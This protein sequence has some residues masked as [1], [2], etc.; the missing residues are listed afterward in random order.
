MARRRNTADGGARM[1]AAKIAFLALSAAFLF[2]STLVL[3]LAGH[4]WAETEAPALGN[5]PSG[6]TAPAE[7]VVPL[8]A[9]E[10]QVLDRFSE[11]EKKLLRMAEL[12]AATDPHR[13]SLLRKA[14]AQSKQ[15][16]IES[17]LSQ[18][19][20]LLGQDRLA[21]AVKSQAAVGQDLTRLLELLLSEDRSKRLQSEKERIGKYIQ[22]VNQLIKQQKQLQGEA[23]GQADLKQIAEHQ[24]QLAEKTGEL[25]RDIGDSDGDGKDK[26]SPDSKAKPDKAKPD[27]AKPNKPADGKSDGGKSDDGKSDGGKSDGGKSDGGKSSKEGKPGDS[28]P[29]DEQP[30]KEDS[31]KKEPAEDPAAEDTKPEGEKE[32]A[33]KPAGGSPGD[34]Q[35]PDGKPGSD[36][37]SPDGAES[38]GKPAE[39]G[40]PAKGKPGGKPSEGSDESPQPGEEQADGGPAEDKPEEE[41]EKSPVR[42]RVAQAEQKM[43]DAQKKL[44]EAQ[45]DQAVQKQEE[46]KR[47][48][49]LAKAELE[50][51][52]RQLR[53]EEV[54]RTLAMLE[55]RFRKMLEL[56]NQVNTGTKRLD[57]ATAEQRDH[58]DEI[59]AGR[60]S[61]QEAAIVVEANKALAVLHDE[62]SAVAFPE[63]VS[64]LRDDMEQVVVRLAQAKVDAL[65]QGLENDIVVALEEMI[66]ALHS[67]QKQQAPQKGAQSGGE[68]EAPLVDDLS[69]IKM[70]RSMQ[71]W[72]NQ[73]TKRYTEMVKSDAS[74]SPDLIAALRRLADREQRIHRVTRDIVV[75][76]NK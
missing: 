55:S 37:S 74:E 36:P 4:V 12:T 51:I 23:A 73:R 19:V 47:D 67:A 30:G 8:A 32:P 64:D 28:Q 27:K 65:T 69:E 68:T 39:S 17:Q 1:S 5:T 58:D 76:R 16:G 10:R 26:K 53:E 25:A 40:S 38:S 70:I 46:A 7:E 71:M 48:L 29:S 11:L 34:K 20:E 31:P 50:A 57:K 62:G 45:R 15:Q 3:G 22:R 61:R 75:G 72:V 33:D 42:E 63:A 24:G 66:A 21:P 9:E 60:L 52:L 59:E 43:R 2:V 56:Q 14:V 13:A 18:L 41:G 35:S 44:A 54:G 6:E 49:E